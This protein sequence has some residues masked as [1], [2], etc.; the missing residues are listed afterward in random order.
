MRLRNKSQTPSK[1]SDVTPAKTHA[2]NFDEIMDSGAST[3]DSVKV[4]NIPKM[5]KK[6]DKVITNGNYAGELL[7]KQAVQAA[8]IGVP[9]FLIKTYDIV[10]V[11]I[12]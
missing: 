2:A 3:G 4:E 12:T 6:M 10:N 8:L 9:S 5:K 11:R 7:P 1:Q